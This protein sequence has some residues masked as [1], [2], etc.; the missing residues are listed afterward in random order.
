MADVY[1]LLRNKE[2]QHSYFEYKIHAN[3]GLQTLLF[4]NVTTMT[5]AY[6]KNP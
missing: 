1:N 2:I 3:S 6:K 4:M 5:H